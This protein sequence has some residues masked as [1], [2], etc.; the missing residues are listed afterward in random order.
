M[1]AT[2]TDLLTGE[3]FV[4]TQPELFETDQGCQFYAVVHHK[5]A[6]P[7]T[8]E[9]RD[10]RSASMKAA[11]KERF[12]STRPK[13]YKNEAWIGHGKDPRLG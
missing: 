6:P 12:W 2:V 8:Q 3:V 7:Q 4:T 10:K 1:S 11:R 9:T 13:P 5:V